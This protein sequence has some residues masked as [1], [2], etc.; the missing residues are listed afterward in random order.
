MT[1]AEL[2]AILSKAPADA[3]VTISTRSCSGALTTVD[4]VATATAWGRTFVAIN[5]GYE[6]PCN[7]E[8]GESELDPEAFQDL[9]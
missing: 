9:A 5:M 6:G 7:E 4:A 8:T 3:E 1:N 2:I